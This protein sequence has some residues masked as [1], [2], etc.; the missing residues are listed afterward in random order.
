MTALKLSTC[1]GRESE[2]PVTYFKS[3]M[4]SQHHMAE[5]VTQQQNSEEIVT[6]ELH[7]RV[8]CKSTTQGGFK[9]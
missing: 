6:K 3:S 9:S 1:N 7:K 2:L 8:L 4:Q 5:D